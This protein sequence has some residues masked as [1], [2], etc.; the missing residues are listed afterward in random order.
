MKKDERN[1][2]IAI[3]L[4]ILI[5]VGVAFAGSQYGSAIA[6]LPLFAVLVALAFVIQWIV[7]IPSYIKPNG[8]IF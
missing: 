4:V 3:P 1:A 7:F 2:L 5:G 8:K 6:G